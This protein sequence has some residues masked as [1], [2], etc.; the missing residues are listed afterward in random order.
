MGTSFDWN[1]EDLLDLWFGIGAGLVVTIGVFILGLWAFRRLANRRR[2]KR[3]WGNPVAVMVSKPWGD[4]IPGTIVNRSEEGV[5]ILLDKTAED[6]LILAVRPCEAPSQIPWVHVRVCH[7]RK[8]GKKW[9]VG[10][11][12]NEEVPYSVRV[13][14]G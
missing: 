7:S 6:N 11:Q 1:V 13:W 3:R 5:A 4:P 12:L 9:L 2:R 14:F 10:C 8:E